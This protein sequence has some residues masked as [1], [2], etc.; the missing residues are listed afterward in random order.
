[1]YNSTYPRIKRNRVSHKALSNHA[2]KQDR[3]RIQVDIL[4]IKGNGIALERLVYK[5][6]QHPSYIFYPIK[7]LLP[8]LSGLSCE[9]RGKLLTHKSRSLTSLGDNSSVDLSPNDVND[10][11][12]ELNNIRSLDNFKYYVS[13]VGRTPCWT[14]SFCRT[15]PL[16]TLQFLDETSEQKFTQRPSFAALDPRVP[17]LRS[18]V[19]G[20]EPLA[21][22]HAV[23]A[24]R[25][26]LDMI[27]KT[28]GSTPAWKL[29]PTGAG[30]G[31]KISLGEILPISP[32]VVRSRQGFH[33]G[34]N[35]IRF[36]TN[37]NETRT[38]LVY[39]GIAK[40]F[41]TVGPSNLS[42]GRSCTSLTIRATCY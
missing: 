40:P 41:S 3:S 15:S 24:A 6:L 37:T 21:T 20:P 16:F 2:S 34:G 29:P 9:Y 17:R 1:M 42:E 38:H 32:W 19:M 10:K 28:R 12:P 23:L 11:G 5:A 31:R 30:R 33:W 27:N 14:Q 13:S 35:F 4:R 18:S 36:W 26:S 7:I 25:P 39:L 22:L 8:I